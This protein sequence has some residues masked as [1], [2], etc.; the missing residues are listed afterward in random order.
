VVPIGNT[1]G[2]VSVVGTAQARGEEAVAFAAEAALSCGV[3]IACE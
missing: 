1:G 2:G 3:F